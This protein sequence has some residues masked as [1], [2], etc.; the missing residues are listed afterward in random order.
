MVRT[1][2]RTA[3]TARILTHPYGGAPR[4]PPRVR[5]AGTG[6]SCPYGGPAPCA[7]PPYTRHANPLSS[8]AAEQPIS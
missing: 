4:I 3:W 2:A 5:R 7:R 1:R 8:R 6:P